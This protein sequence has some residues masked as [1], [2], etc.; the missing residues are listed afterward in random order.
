M[1]SEDVG[2]ADPQAL[3]Q[4]LAARDACEH[5][6][7]P[8]CNL[9]LAQATLYLA[10]APKS[11]SLYT[12]W[13]AA[14]D[15][16]KAFGQ[17]PVPSTFQNA[18]TA[19]DKKRDV[20][21]GYRYDHDSPDAYSGQDHLPESLRGSGLWQPVER[22]FERELKKRLEWFEARREKPEGA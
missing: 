13:K 18:V 5:L 2:L 6:G 17:L 8:E 15:A 16:I 7:L 20:G 3:V 4:A 11:N 9:A 12:G 22:G 1:A 19:F 21:T 14:E 10:M